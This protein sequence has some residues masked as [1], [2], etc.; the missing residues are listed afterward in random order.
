MCAVSSVRFG[1]IQHM[2]LQTAVGRTPD[3]VEREE[4]LGVEEPRR[5]VVAREAAAREAGEAALAEGAEAA[6]EAALREASAREATELFSE[7]GLAFEEDSDTVFSPNLGN[8]AFASASDGW[9]F[10]IKFRCKKG[11]HLVET[12]ENVLVTSGYTYYSKNK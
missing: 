5:A 2:E 1:L 7:Y 10:R 3:G 6:R 9:A 8:V 12:Y 4:T 11:E